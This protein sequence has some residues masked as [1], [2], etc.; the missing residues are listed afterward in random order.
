MFLQIRAL[1][2]E[3]TVSIVIRLCHT[4]TIRNQD[5]DEDFL[6][7]RLDYHTKKSVYKNKSDPVGKEDFYNEEHLSPA[8]HMSRDLSAH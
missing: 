6:H 1:L 8:L 2:N 5:I 7:K 3:T 4:R